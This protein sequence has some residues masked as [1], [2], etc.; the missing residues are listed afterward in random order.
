[1]RQ[2]LRAATSA[3]RVSGAEQQC[4]QRFRAR[5]RDTL[6]ICEAGRVEGAGRCECALSVN[7]AP[8]EAGRHQ[9]PTRGHRSLRD[10]F[11]APRPG[12][13]RIAR[14][15]RWPSNVFPRTYPRIPE[16]P[17][18]PLLWRP[19]SDGPSTRRAAIRGPNLV[20]LTRIPSPRGVSASAAISND[21]ISAYPDSLRSV[22]GRDAPVAN[23]SSTR[24]SC[25]GWV[26]GGAR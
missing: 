9:P 14:Q 17:S 20:R 13:R 15:D 10:R 2:T 25:D 23:F 11:R 19:C 16:A 3:S 8:V 4:F 24:R 21:S 1:M 18:L 12:G 5:A 26:F 22:T 6:R 7:P